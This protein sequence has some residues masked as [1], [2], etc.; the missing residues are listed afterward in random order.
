MHPSQTPQ[1]GISRP[2]Y[3]PQLIET[4]RRSRKRGDPGPTLLPSVKTDLSPGDQVHLPRHLRLP[5]YSSPA[6]DS[7]TDQSKTTSPF[8]V[9]RDSHLQSS[10]APG[11][12]STRLQPDSEESNESKCPSLSTTP[13]AA[14]DGTEQYKHATRLR[15]SCDDRF[16]GY[17]L[18]LAARAAEKQLREQAMA[19]Y[20][21]ENAH[22]PVDHFAIDRESDTSDEEGGVGMLP[23]DAEGDRLMNR[24]ESAAG[25]DLA[26]MRKHQ[27]KLEQQRKRYKATEKVEI[28]KAFQG[29]TPV[30]SNEKKAVGV[31]GLDRMRTAA[32]PA[33][34]GGDLVF[35]KSQSPRATRFDVHQHPVSRRDSGTNADQEQG[36][37]WLPTSSTI[38]PSSDIGLWH[39]V[40]ATTSKNPQIIA[41][42][43][44][45]GLM[46]PSPERDDPFGSFN[47]DVEQQLPPSPSSLQGDARNSG[48][49]DVL[50]LEQRITL[51]FH[52]GF[53][54]QLYNY[55]SLGYPSLA[56]KYDGELSKI[57][58][59]PIEQ[60][61]HDDTRK[62][63]KGYVG[64]P[65]GSGLDLESARNGQCERWKALRLYVREWARQ[66][67]RM[68]DQNAGANDNWGVRARR[69]SWAI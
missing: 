1:S 3:T 45:T 34:A 66:Q 27:E 64:A 11:V 15:E 63:T 24:R 62:N 56:R 5:P 43:A 68:I 33:M 2:K 7:Q 37:L 21:N 18:A 39:G 65:E 31:S 8:S 13:S 10:P 9:S 28:E 53:I 67:P 35:P 46:T 44:Q 38:R 20:P 40:C 17:L 6:I 59:I 19:A 61:R 23:Y 30:D 12:D 41:E 32:S 69:G 54:T 49:D 60:L 55:L 22:E 50:S 14:S 4:T 42:P 52:D 29:A 36:G 16:S 48:I 25:W 47:L 57:S 26:E 58:K 51:E